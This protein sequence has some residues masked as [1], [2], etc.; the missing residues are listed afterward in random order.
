[1]VIQ[2]R[3][4]EV[5]ERIV[6][7]SRST[8]EPYLDRIREAGVRRPNRM[9]LSCSN[10]AHGFAACAVHDKAALKGVETPNIGVVTAYNDMLSAHQP[11]ERY[12]E[13][14]RAATTG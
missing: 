7:R 3:I 14:I 11:Y 13:L 10:L 4:Q 2:A 1:M 6:A 9:Q 12:P 5:T 8:R